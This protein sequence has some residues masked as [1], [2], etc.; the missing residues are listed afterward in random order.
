MV[1]YLKCWPECYQAMKEDR[2][3]FEYRFNDRQFKVGDLL[4]LMEL[5]S[6]HERY[7]GRSI[8]ALVK[9]IWVALPNLPVGYCIMDIEL[10]KVRKKWDGEVEVYEQKDS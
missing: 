2:K 4:V 1:H 3:K 10:M 5:D 8:R 7:T 6:D 9:S